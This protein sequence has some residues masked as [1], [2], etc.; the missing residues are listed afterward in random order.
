M[1]REWLAAF[2]DSQPAVTITNFVDRAIT[3]TT[4][5][6]TLLQAFPIDD[7]FNSAITLA[8]PDGTSRVLSDPI[9]LYA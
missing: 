7:F 8:E 2:F 1:T 5:L 4:T 3:A 9:I 6:C